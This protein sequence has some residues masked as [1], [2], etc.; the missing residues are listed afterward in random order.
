MTQILLDSIESYQKDVR[1]NLQTLFQES[2]PG[3]V[4]LGK[5]LKYAL[6]LACGLSTGSASFVKTL[7]SVMGDDLP[8]PFI[9][10][11]HL[12]ASLMAMTNVYYRA[13]HFAAHGELSA[14]PAR[15]R[16]T[17]LGAPP[18]PKGPFELLCLA[19]SAINGC[20][21]CVASHVKSASEHVSLEWIHESIRIAAIVKSGSVA[22]LLS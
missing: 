21:Q 18:I 2:V 20:E 17:A 15:L 5:D 3:T 7:R 9:Q 19:V 13:K 10:A 14:L 6:I 1:I 16:M 11:A 22:A 4:N 8:E 12:A